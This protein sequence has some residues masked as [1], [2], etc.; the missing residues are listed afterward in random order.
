MVGRSGDVRTSSGS[1]GNSNLMGE[2][3]AAPDVVAS[4]SL[5]TDELDLA[6]LSRCLLFLRNVTPDS[7]CT[8]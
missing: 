7:V 6:P 2:G 1:L 4:S 3:A 8:T 5:S